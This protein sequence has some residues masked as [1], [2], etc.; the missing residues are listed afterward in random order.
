MRRFEFRLESVLRIRRFELERERARMLR[1][2]AEWRRRDSRARELA[3]RVEQG[4]ERLGRI[5][6]GG[7]DG[8]RIGGHA[9]GLASGRFH[10]AQAEAA[11]D[12]LVPQ[13]ESARERT[14]EAS[15]RVRSL[16]KLEARRAIAHLEEERRLEQRELD[17]L[18]ITRAAAETI[19]RRVHEEGRES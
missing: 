3:A 6:E 8:R 15:V 13:L 4:E 18:A 7:M 1:L 17:S 11:R 9:A 19:D 10:R 12:H 16:E 14:R 5:M 2:E